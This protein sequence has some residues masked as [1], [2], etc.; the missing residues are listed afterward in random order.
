MKF[1]SLNNSP[2][3]DTPDAASM[4]EA[5]PEN[6]P[7]HQALRKEMTQKV[8]EAINFLPKRQK[9]ALVLSYY[10]QLTYPEVAEVMGCSTGT[11]KTQVF[12]A[13][14]SLAGKLPTISGGAI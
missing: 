8:N 2:D 9:T 3:T 4:L 12:R 1:V 6:S 10:Q 11:V 14:K 5:K 13:L 7:D